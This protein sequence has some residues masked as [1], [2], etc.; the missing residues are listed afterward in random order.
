MTLAPGL[1]LLAPALVAAF[2]FAASRWRVGLGYA[3]VGCTMVYAGM[4]VARPRRLLAGP[5]EGLG[6]LPVLAVHSYQQRN[7]PAKQLERLGRTP[8]QDGLIESAASGN[9]ALTQLYLDAGVGGDAA[10]VSAAE[11]GQTDTLVLL[12]SRVG[13]NTTSAARALAY[14]RKANQTGAVARLQS[15]GVTL[16]APNADGETALMA[17]IREHRDDEWDLLVKLGANVNARTRTGETALMLAVIAG[18]YPA[19]LVLIG[20]GADVNA[21]DVDGWTPLMRAA[22]FGRVSHASGLVR[23]G[24]NVNMASRLGW[25]PLMWAAYGGHE[26]IVT[27]LLD[28]GANPNATS[29]AGQTPLIRASAQGHQRIVTLLRERGADR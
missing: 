6:R 26:V 2:A 17:A 25:T 20:A 16:D 19:E 11:R 14:A 13:A 7:A 18:D 1:P 9:V 23:A 8:N 28:A 29:I 27:M 15:A 21:A 24:A 22:R 10:L 3:L 4:V 12:L 5:G